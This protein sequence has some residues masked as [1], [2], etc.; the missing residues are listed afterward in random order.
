MPA[1][2]AR[3]FHTSQTHFLRRSVAFNTPGITSATTVEVGTIPANALVLRVGVRIDTAFNAGT[4]NTL[5]VG[6]VGAA[7]AYFGA[8]AAGSQAVAVA[9]ITFANQNPSAVAP[10][11]IFVRY[12]TAGTA[13]S[14]G[15][16]TVW[17]EYAPFDGI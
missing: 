2:T 12:N 9:T 6:Y 10:T 8:Q 3:R 17:V 15:A 7:T 4:T 13:A 14:A 1:V 16:A 11:P 5:D